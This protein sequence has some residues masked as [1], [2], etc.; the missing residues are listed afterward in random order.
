MKSRNNMFR[1]RQGH[2]LQ[3]NEAGL[4]LIEILVVLGIIGLVLGFL[5]K[6]VFNMGESAKASLSK[7][8]LEAI[9]GPL[10]LYQLQNNTLPQ[11]IK[12]LSAVDTEDAWGKPVQYKILDGG[13]SYELKS[14]GADGREG[15]SDANADIIVKGP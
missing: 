7:T 9:K 10:Y 12:S 5:V 14:L 8:K 1:R 4:T 6:N 13:R 11:D 2:S 3:N 15:G